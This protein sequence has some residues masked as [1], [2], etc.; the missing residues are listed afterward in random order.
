MNSCKNCVDL[1]VLTLL[2]QILPGHV[3]K[4]LPVVRRETQKFLKEIWVSISTDVSTDYISVKL[5]LSW[6]RVSCLHS[7]LNSFL[8]FFCNKSA[9]EIFQLWKTKP[10]SHVKVSEIFSWHEMHCLI[11]VTGLTP[12]QGT[13]VACSNSL[14]LVVYDQMETNDWMSYKDLCLAWSQWKNI[15]LQC[16]YFLKT[17]SRW[18]A[19]LNCLAYI[20]QRKKELLST[21]DVILKNH[22]C[23]TFENNVYLG[24]LGYK[25]LKHLLQ[26]LHFSNLNYLISSKLVSLCG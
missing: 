1:W 5:N 18:A 24:S 12:S 22:Y 8:V 17:V 13:F 7:T 20:C 23:I 2:L 3:W 15:W 11:I 14:F 25:L 10:N 19:S 26:C 16:F 4:C 9:S 6:T 21:F